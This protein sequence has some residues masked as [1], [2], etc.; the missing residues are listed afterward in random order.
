[1]KKI[2]LA[3]A[4]G[5]RLTTIL[6]VALLSFQASG[7]TLPSPAHVPGELLVMLDNPAHNVDKVLAELQA[8]GQVSL[9]DVPSPSTGILLLGVASGTEA[10]WLDRLS[11]H[12]KLRAVQLNHIAHER[13][14]VPNDP[15]FG[16]QWHHV[17]S[18]DH[19]IDSD[20]AWDITNGG[21]AGNGARI[22]VAVLEGGGSNYSH[23]DLIDNHWVNL[24]EIPNNNID[25]DNNGYVDDYNGWNPGSG[26]D[27]I[28]GGGHGTSVS[29]MIGATGD[30]GNGGVGVNWDVDIMQIDMP[31]GLTESNVISS[32]E[33]P[34]VMR[35]IFNET[36]GE[37]GAFVVA[38]NA[39][40]GIDAADPSDFPVWCAYY[41][42]LGASGILNCGATTNQSLNVDVA[43][44]MPTACGSDYMLSITA[45]NNND[46]R[47]FS[48][49]GQTTVDLG[50]PG[51]NVWLT[52]GSNGGGTTSGTSFASPCVAGA[53]ALV[54]SV[55]CA[56]LAALALE[57]PQGAADLVRGYIFDGVD[58]VD[59][60]TTETVTGG[61][62]NV[63]NSVELALANCGP[64]ECEPM[65][66]DSIT[67][68]CVYDEQ[69]MAVS[70]STSLS[71]SFNNF[72][73]TPDSVCLAASGTMDYA[74]V[75]LAEAGLDLS[76]A[77]NGDWL[78][79]AS[80]TAYD[81]YFT[82]DST[83]SNVLTFSTPDCAS[84]VPGCTDANALNYNAEA[85]IDDGSCEFPCQD[86]VMTITTDCWPEE[87][88]W[89]I[90]AADGEVLV[91]VPEGEYD[92]QDE[93]VI[94]WTGCVAEGCHELIV[95]DAYGDGMNGSMWGACE[96]DG[97][98][99]FTTLDGAVLAALEEPNFGDQISFSFCLPAIPGCTDM[100]ACNYDAAA[101][102]NDGS[103]ISVGDACDDGDENTV[104]DAI[105]EDCLCAGVLPINGCTDASACNYAMDANVDDGSCVFVGTGAIE[106]NMTP[107]SGIQETYV[108]N[109]A[110]A[111]N[112]YSWS[113][114]GGE[115]LTESFG[116]DVTSV[117]ILWSA[118]GFG[119]VAVNETDASF[120]FCEEIVSVTV[121]V[122][123]NNIEEW[124]AAGVSV[125][126]NPA[127]SDLNL[128]WPS[129][130][131]EAEFRLFDS[132]GRE[133]RQG[134]LAGETM[135]WDV[136]DLA[137]GVYSLMLR[138]EGLQ[139]ST[140]IVLR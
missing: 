69:L 112:A 48:G 140:T 56:E 99:V 40:W 122:L 19:D 94:E 18:G 135:V 116:V 120:Q 96:V 64:I 20:L 92:G 91:D 55:P 118:S 36:S 102:A 21:V 115:I 77:L 11:G 76:N 34:K 33:Y 95:T 133:V 136:S 1:M 13:E 126:P 6:C 79:L 3:H 39:S 37:A 121:N 27:N 30:N 45:T 100:A 127:S 82:L 108:Y 75:N 59:N 16:Q 138:S 2:A 47:T 125:F 4:L 58:P 43:G 86:V 87:T 70:I 124:T 105:Q 10:V 54:Y 81:V 71:A 137:R 24:A 12:A 26:D 23:P 74:C 25:D 98:M 80:N 84:L 119:S 31:G 113:V 49:Y 123:V 17:Q 67:A 73:C 90:V 42:A 60:L 111:G 85:T 83:T 38:T 66:L 129:A 22:V 61:R 9:L 29:G 62:L 109:G 44:D 63:F 106:G 114:N 134:R 131:G 130:T 88:G 89:S 103:C 51:D 35:D 110:T 5:L 139:L 117:D 132:T 8:F 52:S 65:S 97:N 14:T 46:V 57:N 28:A 50:A 7:Q 128:Q 101:N 107:Q 68:A 78:D 93:T 41:D 15:N 32:Y 53:I 104:L 72:L